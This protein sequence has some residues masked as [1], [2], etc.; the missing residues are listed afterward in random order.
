MMRPAPPKRESPI[1]CKSLTGFVSLC[2]NISEDLSFLTCMGRRSERKR[3]GRSNQGQD[4]PPVSLI[5]GFNSHCYTNHSCVGEEERQ[6]DGPLS[7][8]R[9]AV[10]KPGFCEEP[11]EKCH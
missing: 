7:L 4:Q 10:G 1:T 8:G 11:G 2:V 5:E 9:E 3:I 6:R